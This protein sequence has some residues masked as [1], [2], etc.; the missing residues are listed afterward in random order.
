MKRI[1]L[2]HKLYAFNIDISIVKT[3]HTR[4]ENAPIPEYNINTARVFESSEVYELEIE[5]DNSRIDLKTIYSSY[6]ELAKALRLNIKYIL[7]GFARN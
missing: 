1:T 3:S 2:V 4:K 5:I 7:C 6:V